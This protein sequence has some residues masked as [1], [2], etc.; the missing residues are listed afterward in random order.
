MAIVVIGG[1]FFCGMQYQKS[2]FP[3][4]GMTFGGQGQNGA[5]G[6]ARQSRGMQGGLLSGKVV[7]SNVQSITIEM[8]TSGSKIVY[9][10]GSTQV[11]KSVA[12]A[13][14]DIKSGDTVMI[15]GT[16]NQDGSLVAQSI[17]IR[18]TQILPQARQ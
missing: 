9:L 1:S 3:S 8:P 11:L 15:T 12:G 18:P 16:P 5:G 17:Q 6:V 10:S 4:R 14:G 7:S 13:Q 2:Q